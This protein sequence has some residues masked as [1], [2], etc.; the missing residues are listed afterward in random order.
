MSL[1]HVTRCAAQIPNS[2]GTG[3]SDDPFIGDK[4]REWQTV[5]EIQHCLD[6]ITQIY[7]ENDWML[8]PVESGSLDDELQQLADLTNEL[9]KFLQNK[10]LAFREEVRG[11]YR[12]WIVLTWITSVL[13]V[14]GLGMLV[15]LFYVWVFQ[16]MRILIDGSR[17][18]AGGDFGHRI[19]LQTD[20]EVAELAAAMNAMTSRFQQIRDDL[21]RAGAA[22]DAG[23]GAERTTGQCR[24]PGG[25]RGARNQQSAGLHRLVGGIAGIP[26]VRDPARAKT[27]WT[28]SRA[29]N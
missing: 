8:E 3:D 15:R 29:K 27:S 17:R 19:Q 18:V 5:R 6:R 14:V 16:P 22:A 21:D 12:T 13:T 10:M 11:Q 25:R 20:D 7:E 2:A 23:S 1:F 24:L 28:R 9:P 4:R 26:P